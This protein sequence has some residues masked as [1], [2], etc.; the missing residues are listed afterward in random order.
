M[1]PRLVVVGPLPPPLHGVSVSTALVLANRQLHDRFEVEHLDTSDHR[2]GVNLGRWDATNLALGIRHVLRLVLRRGRR[3]VIYLPLSQGTS[4]FLRDSLL[5]AVAS[6]RGWTVAAH[7]RGSEFDAFYGRSSRPLRAWIRWTMSRT[8]SVAVLGSSLRNVFDGL[9]PAD[10]VAVVPNGTPDLCPNGF[11]A[12][13]AVLFLSN[14]RRRKGVLEAVEAALLVLER[15]PEAS[16][17]FAGEW[18]DGGLRDQ[19]LE[20][21]RAAADR[22]RFLPPV[23]GQEKRDLLLSSCALLFPPREPEGHPRVVL[24]AL[25]AGLPVIT[26]ARGA[27]AETVVD[28]R[29]GFVLAEP[30]PA[31]LA[32]RLV[33]ILRD[34]H[35]HARLADGARRRYLE[36][37]TQECADAILADWLERVAAGSGS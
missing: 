24:E 16:F 21:T 17:V 8:D 4:G 32:E 27:I 13:G 35:L 14:L 23:S 15:V 29:S 25:S 5:V 1:R 28:G 12:G 20:R 11:Q 2:P 26:T 30:D 18:E 22:F 36:A 7:L 3:G 37:Y 9:V 34:P 33:R 19:V 10:R 6:V 31:E